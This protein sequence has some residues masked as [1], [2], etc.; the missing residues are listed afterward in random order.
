LL[1]FLLKITDDRTFACYADRWEAQQ[2]WPVST[3]VNVTYIV[4]KDGV[5]VSK[6]ARARLND[7]RI[8][9]KSLRSG[10]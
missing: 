7:L 10:K 8:R 9:I 2:R 4:F 6:R 1:R 3:L 5:L